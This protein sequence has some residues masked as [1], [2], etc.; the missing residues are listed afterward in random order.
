MNFYFVL[1]QWKTKKIFR[2]QVDKRKY[3]NYLLNYVLKGVTYII[4]IIKK[5]KEMERRHFISNFEIF[6]WF[7]HNESNDHFV[8]MLV[9]LFIPIENIRERHVF[10]QLT[11]ACLYC[12]QSKED[13]L[14]CY[15]K[16]IILCRRESM[17]I[18]WK[19]CR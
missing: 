8:S 16:V 3:L 18:F 19:L 9:S 13:K 1:T 17:H 14:K 15:T 5:E 7:I 2:I 6:F 4:H 11:F 12:K 10:L